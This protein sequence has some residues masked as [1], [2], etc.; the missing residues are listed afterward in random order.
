MKKLPVTVMSGF[1]GAGKTTLLNAILANREGLK[2]AVIVND[3]SEINIDSE[4]ISNGDA[5]LSRTDE[6]LVE[7]TNGCICC[8]LRDDL[9]KEVKRLS[10]AKKYDYLLIESTGISEPLPVAQTFTFTTEDGASLSDVADLQNLLTVVDAKNFLEDYFS[11]DD[12]KDRD[13][14]AGEAD[15]RGLGDLLVEQVEFADIIVVSKADLVTEEKLSEVVATL[16]SLNSRAQIL[17]GSK[18]DIPVEEIFKKSRFNLEEIMSSPQWLKELNNKHVPETEEYG[19][20]SFVFREKRP[21]HPERLINSL[22]SGMWKKVVRSKGYMWLATR[23]DYGAMWSQAGTSC[24][25][26]PAGRWLCAVSEDEWPVNTPDDRKRYEKMIEGEYG[27]RRQEFVVIGKEMDKA[28]L[29]S[30][31]NAA[32]L[33]DD[34]LAGGMESWRHFTDPF[35]EWQFDLDGGA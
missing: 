15:H 27:D 13:I 2:V 3:M 26:E 19:I 14:Q 1:L 12:L 35:P 8:T 4:L 25:L 21:F 6:T 9:L 34:E 18:G 33:T 10:D 5:N 22:N 29:I 31:L 30:V 7:M 24:K 20:S 32:L 16:K 17:I 28:E 11:L 23:N